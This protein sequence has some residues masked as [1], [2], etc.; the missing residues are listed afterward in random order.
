M[1][2]RGFRRANSGITLAR[3]IST[4]FGRAMTITGTAT[5][6]VVFITPTRHIRPRVRTR[7]VGRMAHKMLRQDTLRRS[8][9]G[10][11]KPCRI[12]AVVSPP[13]VAPRWPQGR[14]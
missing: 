14:S 6:T 11:R 4:A 3:R 8:S 1:R 7:R 10:L 12:P 5:R 9:T 2:T 13:G